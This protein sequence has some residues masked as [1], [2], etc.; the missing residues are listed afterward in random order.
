MEK[1]VHNIKKDIAKICWYM[2]GGLTYTEGMNMSYDER[3]MLN[4]IIKDNLN[5]TKDTGLPFF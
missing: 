4:E 3:K 2:R 1:E 5:T